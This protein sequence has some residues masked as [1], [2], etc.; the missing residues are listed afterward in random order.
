[1]AKVYKGW[2]RKYAYLDDYKKG[3]D[4]T[5]VYYGRH[6][7]FR[8]TEQ[9]LRRYRMILLAISLVSAALFIASG[10]MDGG[11]I[12]SSWYVVLPFAIEV[13]I[14]FLLIWKAVTLLM[15]KHPVKSYLYKKTVPW[16]KPLGILLTI[17]SLLLLCMAGLCMI[18]QPDLVRVTGCVLFMILQL[19]MAVS[20]FAFVRLTGRYTW[21]EDPSETPE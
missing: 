16:F 5:Y 14:I 6:H 1:M 13:V 19:L 12:W 9:E 8:G 17:V 15:E 10:L 3:I 18:L 11:A 20:A 7:V 2:K 4:G 21:E